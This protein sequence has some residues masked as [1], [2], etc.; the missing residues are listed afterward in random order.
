MPRVRRVGNRLYALL[1]GY[2][3]ARQVTD[4]ASGMR[5]VRRDALRNLLPLP[6]GLH[7]TPA[8]S[9]RALLNNL[10]VLEVPMPYEERIGLSKLSVLRDGARFLR[11]IFIGLLCYRPEKIF[12]AA[13]A[14]CIIGI[15]LMAAHPTEFY[16]SNRRLEEWMIYRF[17]A[18]FLLGSFGL[19][20]L[21]ATAL[22][23]KMAHL[24]ARRLEANTFWPALTADLLQGR[25]LGILIATLLAVA[26]LFLW[27]GLVE[28]ATTGHVSMHWSRLLAGAFALFSIAH[29]PIFAVLL[30]IVAIWKEQRLDRDQ[31]GRWTQS[32]E[33][34]SQNLMKSA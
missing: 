19:L 20:L 28:F 4:T 10:R 9:A 8:M 21:L 34:V 1:L 16:F 23:N 32:S 17:V 29:V 24:S 3:S 11:E 7:F 6:D 27:P 2:L 33:P 13:F 31:H 5:V 25:I 26:V 18:C 15:L 12:L 30:R 14:L 22:T